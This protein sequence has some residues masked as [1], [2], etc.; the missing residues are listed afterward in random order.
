[1]SVV[2]RDKLVVKRMSCHS[3]QDGEQ[4]E[5]SMLKIAEG[6]KEGFQMLSWSDWKPWEKAQGR[7]VA[8]SDL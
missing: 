7:T 4:K 1:M 2:T 3:P 5:E 6:R 8:Q